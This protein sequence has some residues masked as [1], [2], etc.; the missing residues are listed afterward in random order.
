MNTIPIV[1]AIDPRV[2]I[3][4]GVALSSLLTCASKG[5]FYDIYILHSD[6]HDFSASK[7]NALK[8]RFPACNI[9]FR[10]VNG[11]FE[12]AFEIR[13]ITEACYYRLLI[14]EL[15]PEYDKVLYSDVDVIF[16]RD[17]CSFYETDLGDNYFGGVNIVKSMDDSFLR[18]IKD[19]GLPAEKGYINSGCLIFNS[20]KLLED[21]KLMQFR[22]LA[23]RRFKYQDQDIINIA[24]AG[25][26]LFMPVGFNLTTAMYESLP[27]GGIEDGSIADGTVHYAG[28]KPWNEV[29]PN[30]D[31][32]WKYYR[33]SIFFDEKFTYDFWY[34]QTYRAEMMSLMKR[35][36]HVGRY[37]RKGGRK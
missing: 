35:I 15:I 12:G 11:E 27:A 13:G 7:I 33:N 19:L 22:E 25:K 34:R 8:D 1:L 26:I 2:E 20:R 28:P 9:T 10:P 4:A 31:I 5:T 30:M 17:L 14:P 23:R 37:F 21:G 16:R 3:P 24:C 18:H 32:W 29:C 36:K 6:R